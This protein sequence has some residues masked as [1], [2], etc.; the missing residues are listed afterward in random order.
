MVCKQI[1]G[2]QRLTSTGLADALLL[3]QCL[4][5]LASVSPSRQDLHEALRHYEKQMLERAKPE[6]EV[7]YDMNNRFYA[8]DTAKSFAEFFEQMA[9]G[10]ESIIDEGLQKNSGTGIAGKETAHMIVEHTP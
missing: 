3:G 10:G 9:A 4:V 5:K 2:T 8:P 1:I 6:M 7:S